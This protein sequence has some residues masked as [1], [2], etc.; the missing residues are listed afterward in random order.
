[1]SYFDHGL[2]TASFEGVEFPVAGMP[3]EEGH[4]LIAHVAKGRRGADLEHA[5]QNPSAG[6]LVIPLVN[7]TAM[8]RR[9][10]TL[11]PDKLVALRAKFVETPV[12]QLFHPVYGAFTA[13]IKSW[14]I[15]PDP[16]QRNALMLKVD[17][18][19]HN[20]EASLFLEDARTPDSPSALAV[21]AAILADALALALGT[22]GYRELTSA[23]TT[24]VELVSDAAATPARVSAQIETVLADV[25]LNASLF[26][27]ASDA[28]VLAQIETAR[29]QLYA[30]RRS[31]LDDIAST[32]EVPQTMP[33]HEIAARV[34]GDSRMAARLAAAN[35]LP[36]PLAVPAGTVIVIPPVG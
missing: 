32:W 36:D 24:V 18:I 27:A 2:A 34:Y 7:D 21:A 20:G 3:T 17:W 25:E 33:V 22:A 23:I 13:G 9:W 19:E 14:R 8:V 28:E 26:S 16:Q 12:G 11:L 15:D 30:L 5:Q 1:M 31:I 6:T 10:G 4:T 35:A 29:A